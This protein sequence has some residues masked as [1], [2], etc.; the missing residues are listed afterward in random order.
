MPRVQLVFA[1]QVLPAPTLPTGAR[2]ERA[3][4]PT[5]LFRPP[6]GSPPPAILVTQA[7]PAR[8]EEVAVVE[9]REAEEEV[10]PVD[11]EERVA[12]AERAEVGASPSQASRAR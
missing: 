4:I 6:T 7:T 5:A 1:T 3:P 8:E 10:E 9:A 2:E 12:L 11:V